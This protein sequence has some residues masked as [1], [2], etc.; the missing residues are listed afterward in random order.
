MQNIVLKYKEWAKEFF[1]A[2]DFEQKKKLFNQLIQF[3]Y[4]HQTRDL[5]GGL[6]FLIIEFLFLR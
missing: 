1:Q 5:N 3:V 6:R 2:E 4:Q